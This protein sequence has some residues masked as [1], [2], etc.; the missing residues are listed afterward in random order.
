MV[1]VTRE[2]LNTLNPK[3]YPWNP[4][5]PQPKMVPVSFADYRFASTLHPDATHTPF[6]STRMCVLSIAPCDYNPFLGSVFGFPITDSV[7]GFRFWVPHHR[8]PSPIP[9]C[10]VYL[11]PKPQTPEPQTL[12]YTYAVYTYAVYT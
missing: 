1:P 11:N 6:S 10:C 2:T 4:E 7:L 5:C 12:R 9:S 3:W 8:F